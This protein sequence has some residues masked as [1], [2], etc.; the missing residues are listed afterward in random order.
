MTPWRKRQSQHTPTTKVSDSVLPSISNF[1][2][3]R[4]FFVVISTSIPGTILL[5]N[6]SFVESVCGNII[7]LF[8]VC[9]LLT[10]KS[11]RQRMDKS[12][13]VNHDELVYI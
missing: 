9:G 13:Q 2:R 12:L 5:P 1:I 6:E 4:N 7:R 10:V 8:S 3:F 11:R